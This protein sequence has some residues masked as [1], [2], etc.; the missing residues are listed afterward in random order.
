MKTFFYYFL[1]FVSIA[2]VSFSGSWFTSLGLDWY[3]NLNLPSFTPAGSV[4]GL[5]WSI[6]FF[7]ILVSLILFI[8]R[9]KERKEFLYR[10]IILLFVISG[11][12]NILWSAV[13]FYWQAILWSILEM[14][15]LNL[16]NL[17]LI[18]LLWQKNKLSSILLW[19]YFIWVSFATYLAYS[20]WLLN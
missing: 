15:F 18:I 11:L 3:N 8:R 16:V 17:V 14:M 9:N 6:I 13:F 12:L 1:A 19:P 10:V 4:I 20:I 5:I 2:L 7:L